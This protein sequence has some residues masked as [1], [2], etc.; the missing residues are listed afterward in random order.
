M[1]KIHCL[2]FDQKVLQIAQDEYDKWCD[3][4]EDEAVALARAHED[5]DRAHGGMHRDFASLENMRKLDFKKLWDS[6][7]AEKVLKKAKL[8]EKVSAVCKL[9][10]PKIEEA[11]ERHA[12]CATS[13][14]RL[15]KSW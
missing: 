14:D 8:K 13:P 1:S 2:A 6:H 4:K 5:D 15:E 11:T 10:L 3:A 7:K 9:W 12:C